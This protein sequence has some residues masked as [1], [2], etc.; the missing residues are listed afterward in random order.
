MKDVFN[1]SVLT[2][3]G[4]ALSKDVSFLELR[5]LSGV[6]GVYPGHSP[7]LSVIRPSVCKISVENEGDDVFFL[8]SG[9]INIRPKEVILL[10]RGLERKSDLDTTL[11]KNEEADLKEK[12][13]ALSESD[14]R[15]D[16]DLALDKVEARLKLLELS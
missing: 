12:L 16:L 9:M 4:L 2:P 15:D 7:L 6:L 13:S 1:L 5:T 10:T 11:L 14:S 3:S 8:P